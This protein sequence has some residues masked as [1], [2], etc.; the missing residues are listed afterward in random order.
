MSM[1][2]QNKQIVAIFFTKS[3]EIGSDMAVIAIHYKQA[4]LCMILRMCIC[5]KNKKIQPLLLVKKCQFKRVSEGI[6][7]EFICCAL[8]IQ[9]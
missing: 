4:S 5:F 7:A 3:N 6:Q 1:S 8:K 2:K 9:Y